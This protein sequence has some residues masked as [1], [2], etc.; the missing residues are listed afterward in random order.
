MPS[1]LIRN[2]LLC[3]R[4]YRQAILRILDCIIS[5]A[6]ILI[7]IAIR[8]E[9][10]SPAT[11]LAQS[12]WQIAMLL[13]IQLLAFQGIGIYKSVLRYSSVRLI[14]ATARA[15][16]LSV[17]S[18]IAVN[19]F[20][21]GWALSRSVI[22]IN[23]LLVLILTLAGRFMIR[24]WISLYVK[25]ESRQT[26]SRQQLKRLLI[27]GAGAAGAELLQAL[28]HDPYYTV[29]GFVDDS[30]ELHWHADIDGYRV[31]PFEHIKSLWLD[32]AF[33]LVV[34]AM[35]SVAPSTRRKIVKRLQQLSMPFKTVPNLGS[36]LSGEV[37]INEIRDI[38]IADL[39]GRKEA[40]PDRELLQKQIRG[41]AVLVTG[42]GG[43]IGSEL[44]RQII[45]QRPKCLV[46][47]ELNEFALYQIHQELTEAYPDISC[48][49]CLG[50]V[51]DQSYLSAVL[52]T[53]QIETLYHAAAYKHVPL[54]ESNIAK[55]VENNIRG[56]LCAT[57]S[58]IETGV[59]QFVLISTD[60]AVRPTNVMGT[61]KRSAELIVQAQA[62]QSES[63]TCFA[64]VRF[65]NVLGSSGSVVPRF[66]AQIAKGGPITLTHP[67]ITRYFMSIPEAARLVIQAGAMAQG[68]EVFLLDMGEP[69]KIYDLATQMIR[70]SG[71]IPDEDIAIE[72]TGLRP[73]EK[74]YEELLISGKCIQR[75]RHD[76]IY[77]SKE[78]YLPWATLEPMLN[79]LFDHANCN[80][81]KAIKQLL[82]QLVPEYTPKDASSPAGKGNGN[83]KSVQPSKTDYS[84]PASRADHP[85]PNPNSRQLHETYVS[86]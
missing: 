34:L 14:Q 66:K 21:G 7:A 37:K 1:K 4:R 22:I 40:V 44:C 55:G 69:V 15:V 3:K 26:Y 11:F 9:Q 45:Q 48:V 70:L 23:A 43:S 27:Y 68:G 84:F 38:D 36:I 30:P 73:G 29:I 83:D 25:R 50:N 47:Y 41:K 82:Q 10:S 65:G 57:R 16:G 12:K 35:P 72:I 60:K 71:L 51:A 17:T 80:D 2:L 39:L 19:Y 52:R 61:T 67:D 85:N 86:G 20:L 31:Y 24:Q 63:R 59:R 13:G 6:A 53:H 5:I 62:A 56:T 32:N 28:K 33:D 64:I 75:T 49:P 81:A 78:Y 54:L 8:F 76:Q 74:L 79:Q 46:L 42:A 58:A 18:M 77:C